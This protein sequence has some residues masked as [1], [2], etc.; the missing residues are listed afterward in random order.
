MSL[1]SR[2]RNIG[3]VLLSLAKIAGW[4]AG[5]VLTLGQTPH[6]WS[7]YESYG[8]RERREIDEKIRQEIYYLLKKEYI[9]RNADKSLV[10][11][12]EGLMKAQNLIGQKMTKMPKGKYLIVLYDIPEKH[13][14]GRDNFRNF[15]QQN[16]F[17][18][19]QES[20][21]IS[22]SDYYK[23]LYN[24]IFKSGLADWVNI[25]VVEKLAF[26]PE[27]IKKRLKL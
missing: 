10:L 18:K 7:G 8:V 21:W 25:L 20:V 2:D 4:S 19:L 9:V 24:Y 17:N 12:E 11:T 5:A 26:V 16:G 27:K 14:H 15:L 22:S 6:L 13:N 23:A 3:N 1:K